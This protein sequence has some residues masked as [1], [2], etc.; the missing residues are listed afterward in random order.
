MVF[1]HPK[2]DVGNPRFLAI[3]SGKKHSPSPGAAGWLG[4]LVAGW[5]V[6]W[7]GW[8]GWLVGWL[9]GLGWAGLGWL[10]WA[11]WLTGRDIHI[12]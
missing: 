4:G 7:A 9:A 5:W 8:A 3:S 1:E 10:G 6:G 11:G 2:N 12:H